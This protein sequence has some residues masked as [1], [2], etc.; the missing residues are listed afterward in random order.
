MFDIKKC[1]FIIDS[2]TTAF[3]VSLIAKGEA[4]NCIFERKEGIETDRG[5][6]LFCNFAKRCLNIA[7]CKE[8]TVPN[9][10][11]WEGNI[12]SRLLDI[13]HC[14][15][16]VRKKFKE[17][18]TATYVGPCT[19]SIMTCLTCSPANIYYLY[20]GTIDCYRYFKATS[21]KNNN[22]I[23]QILKEF[24][25]GCLLNV[26]NSIWNGFFSLQGFSLI[27][28]HVPDVIWLNY[29]NFNSEDIQNKLKI[30]AETTK[31]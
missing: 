8:I 5:Y 24:I 30:L 10:F 29:K 12:F 31:K 11:I 25:F 22:K 4:V 21:K 14:I 13:Y 16:K 28:M 15:K 18:P 1:I 9:R 2:P 7:S 19:S 3:M 26:P 17:D 27:N 23:K 6:E 20:H